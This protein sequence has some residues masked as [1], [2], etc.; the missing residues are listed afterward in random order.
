MS[1]KKSPLI[2][3]VEV[4]DKGTLT[5]HTDNIQELSVRFYLI[6]SEILFSRQPFLASKA[7]QFS[8]VKPYVTV[9]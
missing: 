8:F 9:N 4:D 6:D 5:V 3:T 1:R 2:L 7:E